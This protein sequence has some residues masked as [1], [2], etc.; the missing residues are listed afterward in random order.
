MSNMSTFPDICSTCGSFT[1]R[2]ISGDARTPRI[3]ELL[4]CNDVPS[5]SELS[6][7]RDII[8]QGPGR[9]ANL[10]QKIAHTKE[11]HDTLINHRNVVET[12]IGDAKVLC[13][14]VRRLPPDVLHS[15]ALETIPSPSEIMGSNIYF[16]NSLDRTRAPWTLSQVCRSW[17]MAIVGS[18][19]LW[20]SISLNIKYRPNAPL[21]AFCRPFFLLVLH[22]ERSQSI[23]L[24]FW[25]HDTMRTA[26]HPFLSL[27]A[28]RASSIKNLY[29]SSNLDC[30]L[31]ALPAHGEVGKVSVI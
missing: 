24:T 3:S 25:I 4:R 12:D 10:D 29:L 5:D 28:A 18:P 27:V 19:E 14:P 11:L 15:I 21:S 9:I 7:F 17:R 8:Q 13:S 1:I 2:R 31:E 20:S 6:N 23:P 22:L 30:S 16:H 26:E